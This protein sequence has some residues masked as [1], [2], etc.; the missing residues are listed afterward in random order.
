MER[1]Q[2]WIYLIGIL[3]GWAIGLGRSDVTSRLKAFL[4]PLLSCL[5]VS[6][7]IHVPRAQEVL[8]APSVRTQIAGPATSAAAWHS[9]AGGPAPPHA[10]AMSRTRLTSPLPSSGPLPSAMRRSE[11]DGIEY[12]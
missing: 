10:N 11:V 6:A 3:A 4:W 5:P 8:E 1:Q 9:S 2:S 12:I 7:M